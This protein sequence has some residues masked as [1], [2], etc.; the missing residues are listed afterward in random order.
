MDIQSQEYQWIINSF[1]CTCETHILNHLVFLLLCNRQLF[2]NLPD[3][4]RV[5]MQSLIYSK[6]CK[7]DD[8]EVI[9]SNSK[10]LCGYFTSS[11]LFW[12]TGRN[13]W[14]SLKGWSFI[15][16][17]CLDCSWLNLMHWSG[18]GSPSACVWPGSPE[19]SLAQITSLQLRA[20]YCISLKAFDF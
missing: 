12:H 16:R 20:G 11:M 2:S 7:E 4:A 10:A 5:H 18:T 15:L 17:R 8:P 19:A 3:L 6:T 9:C 14:F 1:H 13:M